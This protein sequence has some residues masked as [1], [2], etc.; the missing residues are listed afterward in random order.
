MTMATPASILGSAGKALQKR[1]LIGGGIGAAYGAAT[2]R[3]DRI[4]GA[5]RGGLFGA[6]IGTAIPLKHAF[7]N[8]RGKAFSTH[9]ADVM[10]GGGQ[11]FDHYSAGFSRS[12]AAPQA[13]AAAVAA[14]SGGATSV[15]ART[16]SGLGF[17]GRVRRS[18]SAALRI[19]R[20]PLGYKARRNAGMRNDITGMRN[21]ISRARSMAHAQLRRAADARNRIR[22]DFENRSANVLS[23]Q[24]NA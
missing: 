4:G 6:A 1:L 19:I 21:D 11:M 15:A 13:A 23:R 17:M 14:V 12:A 10:E 24:D 16:G 3:G 20:D 2:N 5:V 7:R 8:G 18:V 22:G 9:F